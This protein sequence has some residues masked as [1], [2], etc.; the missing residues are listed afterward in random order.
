MAVATEVAEDRGSGAMSLVTTAR[1]HNL[2]THET[3]R[4]SIT[5]RCSTL[6]LAP[7]RDKTEQNPQRGIPNPHS[8]IR[9]VRKAMGCS[10]RPCWGRYK[11]RGRYRNRKLQEKPEIDN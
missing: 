4:A 11:I 5:Q 7:I 9:I 2:L 1:P 3:W 8:P 10:I 6:R